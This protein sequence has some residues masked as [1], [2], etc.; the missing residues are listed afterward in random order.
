MDCLKIILQNLQK[1]LQEFVKVKDRVLHDS[2]NKVK[3]VIEKL[4]LIE[5]RLDNRANFIHVITI[6]FWILFF[7]NSKF[8]FLKEESRLLEESYQS[9]LTRTRELHNIL[10]TTQHNLINIERTNDKDRFQVC[11]LAY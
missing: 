9:F 11:Y 2:S 6:F 3:E 5:K 1:S 4:T 8:S 10:E 7:S